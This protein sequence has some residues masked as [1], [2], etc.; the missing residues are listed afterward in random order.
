M[1]HAGAGG[2]RQAVVYRAAVNRAVPEF[3][4]IGPGSVPCRILLIVPVTPLDVRFEGRSG[5]RQDFASVTEGDSQPRL[6]SPD[7]LLAKVSAR[8]TYS[9]TD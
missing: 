2:R 1:L 3:M 5:L 7:R 9:K 6:S 8:I 4:A